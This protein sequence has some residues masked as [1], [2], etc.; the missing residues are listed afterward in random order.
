MVS[1][2]YS[3]LEKQFSR[4]FNIRHLQSIAG[5][6][7]AVHMPT[8]S[9]EAR[10]NALSEATMLISDITRSSQM[11]DALEEAKSDASM[12]E[13]WQKANLREAEI[14]LKNQ[15]AVDPSLV[16][17]KSKLEVMCEHA[18]RKSRAENNWVG[19]VSQFKGLVDL[20]REEA[21]QRK[22]QEHAT[23]Y[24]AMLSLHEPGVSMQAL[25]A[26]F[27]PLKVFLLDFIPSVLEK[28]KSS[29]I[30]D[31]SGT[32]P[33]DAQKSVGLELMKVLGFD[34]GRGRLDVSVHPF[35]GGVPDDVRI[36]TRYSTNDFTQSLM[37]V[38]HETGHALYE[39]HL[40][41]GYLSQPVGVARGMAVHESQS[42]MMEMQ[43]GRSKEFLSYIVP[44]LSERLPS[45]AQHPHYNVENLCSYFREVSPGLIRVDADEV[46]YPLHIMLRYEIE[47]SLIQG[48][49]QVEDIPALWDEKMLAY[50]GLDTKGDFKNGCLQDIH[51]P[52]GTFGYFPSYS[53]GAM[54]AAQLRNAMDKS[55]GDVPAMLKKGDFTQVRAWLG[56]NVWSQ[57]SYFENYDALCENATGERLN[58]SY[59]I[60]H[61]KNRY[62]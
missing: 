34:F 1:K 43:L 17:K 30:P 47:S 11:K 33:I 39:Q 24:D 36:T 41:K 37:G 51:W 4:I 52:S 5:W 6:D 19:F 2:G 49:A 56:K 27:S 62:A 13:P 20:V 29:P 23:S 53:L 54:L 45:L 15:M 31:F 14:F 28:Q 55:I 38:V 60:D 35:C 58:P 21:R 46:T 12:L 42:L 59:F 3:L 22:T 9:V 57:A 50:L 48:D 44:L 40:P 61:L 10:A 16:E 18:W 32:Y 25:D 8:A 7:Q 26:I